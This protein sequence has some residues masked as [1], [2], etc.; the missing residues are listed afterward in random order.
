MQ[1]Q[2]LNKKKQMKQQRQSNVL[3]LKAKDQHVNFSKVDSPNQKQIFQLANLQISDLI[4]NVLVSVKQV[5]ADEAATFIRRLKI[6]GKR[7]T[8]YMQYQEESE[9][10]IVNQLSR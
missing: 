6:E 5:E 10:E 7:L 2:P 3:K 8:C 4:Q 1:L 9:T